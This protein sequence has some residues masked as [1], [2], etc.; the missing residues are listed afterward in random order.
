MNFNPMGWVLLIC[1]IVFIAIL[2][3]TKILND[4]TANHDGDN[5]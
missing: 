2:S 5:D 3:I 1:L 4:V